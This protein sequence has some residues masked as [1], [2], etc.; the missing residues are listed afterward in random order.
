LFSRDSVADFINRSFEPVWQSVRPVPVV[1]IDFGNGT[2]LTRTLHGNIL[3]S[4]CTAEGLVLDALPGIYAPGAYVNA[5]NQLRLL[6]RYTHNLPADRRAAWVRDYHRRQAEA[7]R[8]GQTPEQFAESL[9]IPPMTK[10][11]IERPVEVVL[12]PGFATAPQVNLPAVPVREDAPRLAGDDVAR[13]KAL[14]EDT[15]LNEG[16]RRRQIH[17]LLAGAGPARPGQVTRPIYKE[18]LHA[19]L[20]DPYLGLGAVLFAHYPFAKEEARPRPAN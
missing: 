17:E 9:R 7:L 19:D 13:W 3:T 12:R 10:A 20:D 6:A 18:V 1:R 4:V 5:L 15:R 14:A 8:K 16:T 2:V 11:A